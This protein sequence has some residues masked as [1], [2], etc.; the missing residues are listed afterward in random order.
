MTIVN[1][2][3]CVRHTN[4]SKTDLYFLVVFLSLS[5]ELNVSFQLRPFEFNFTF[6][7]YQFL[8]A[9]NVFINNFRKKC[10]KTSGTKWSYLRD[11]S[12]ISQKGAPIPRRRGVPIYLLFGQ[13]FPK[14]T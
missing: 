7:I 12:R 10:N 3:L 13:I 9:E 1:T 5:L 11:G 6:G 4:K 8:V 2:E 14:T